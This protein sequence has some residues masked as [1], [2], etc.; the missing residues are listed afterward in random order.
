MSPATFRLDPAGTLIAPEE[1]M[2][3]NTESVP[4]AATDIA[5]PGLPPHPAWLSAASV[6][7]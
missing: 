7:V 6:G 2:V 4:L 1:T 5:I 3:P